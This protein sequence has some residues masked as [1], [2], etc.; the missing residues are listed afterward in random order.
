M[1]KLIPFLFLVLCAG[2]QQRPQ[3]S[4][5]Q[6]EDL[7]QVL[8]IYSAS[9]Q[10]SFTVFIKLP[11]G[12]YAAKQKNYPVVY[13]LDA[14]FYF[15]MIS[16]AITKSIEVGGLPP[17]IVVGIGYQNLAMMD[18][19]RDRDFTYPAADKKLGMSLSGGA[20][21]FLFFI[22]KELIPYVDSKYPNNSKRVLVGHSCGGYFASYALSRHLAN[23]D[24]NFKGYL[25]ASPSLEYGDGYLLKQ[26]RTMATDTDAGMKA[27]F[28]ITYGG[29]EDKDNLAEDPHAMTSATILKSLDS[30]LGK[31]KRVIY[32]KDSFPGLAHM[33]TPFPSFMRGLSWMLGE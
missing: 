7:E 17:T 10:D 27:K 15:D 24:T 3:Y 8:R 11:Q 13:L 23:R 12:Y 2:C 32:E 5:E 20:E 4:K 30:S 9:V 25:A 18:S 33:E 16:A 29:Q 31:S 6:T 19:L 28:Y 1:N 26:F 14:N 22:D 21:Q